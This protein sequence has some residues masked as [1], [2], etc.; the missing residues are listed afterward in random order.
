MYP[1]AYMDS[2]SIFEETQLPPIDRFYSH[3]TDEGI[4]EKEYEH[5]KTMWREFDKDR[6]K[7]YHDLYLLSDVLLIADVFKN[8]RNVCLKNYQLDPAWYYT[9]PW[10]AALK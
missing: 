7:D 4:S 9:S 2:L 3:L 5:T 6:M 1:Y 10:D 8:F